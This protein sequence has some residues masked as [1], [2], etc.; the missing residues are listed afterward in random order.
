MPKNIISPNKI[1]YWSGMGVAA[2]LC[3]FAAFLFLSLFGLQTI[4]LSFFVGMLLGV[5]FVIMQAALYS[6]TDNDKKIYALLG[7]IFAIMFAGFISIA[8]YVQL[9]VVLNNPLELTDETIKLISYAPGSV[10][11]ALDML[12]FTFLCLSVLALAPLFSYKKD[13]LLTSFIWING[14]FVPPTFIFPV[15]FVSQ[16]STPSDNAGSIALFIWCLIFLPVPLLLASR[17]NQ[18][19]AQ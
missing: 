10:A 6:A 1:V 4:Y 19:P 12:G 9:A 15:F 5:S 17:F 18:K 7:L 16:N 2:T 3:L 8:Y 13:R 14:L 11:F